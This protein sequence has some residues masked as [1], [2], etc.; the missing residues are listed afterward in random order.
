[1]NDEDKDDVFLLQ[2]RRSEKEIK[3]WAALCVL[4]IIFTA[5]FMLS[6]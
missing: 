4:F 3:L 2:K 5:W 6:E 1:M